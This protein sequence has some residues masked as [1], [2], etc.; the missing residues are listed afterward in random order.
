M[1]AQLARDCRTLKVG[2]CTANA[3]QFM[4]DDVVARP[5]QLPT[6]SAF[7]RVVCVPWATTQCPL[8][9]RGALERQV[10]HLR[11]R[12][13]CVNVYACIGQHVSGST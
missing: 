11:K 1:P 6:F 4:I 9:F 7:S 3:L 10:S 5:R 13:Q 2:F 8:V 12:N